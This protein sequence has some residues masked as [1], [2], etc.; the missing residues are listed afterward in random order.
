MIDK[1][2][3]RNGEDV[4]IIRRSKTLNEY[5]DAE[6]GTQSDEYVKAIISTPQE[7]RQVEREG[8]ML[9]VD[10]E[11]TMKADVDVTIVGEGLPDI[12]EFTYVGVKRQYKAI[13]R[14]VTQHP[15]NK[16]SKQRIGLKRIM[17]GNE[18]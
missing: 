9:E 11:V 10:V 5:D 3:K 7:N 8:R 13:S 1:M 2:I 12:F 18:V 4:R 17:E 16:L 14:K 6:V 15:Y